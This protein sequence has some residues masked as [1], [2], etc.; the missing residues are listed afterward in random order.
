MRCSHSASNRRT[1]A[2]LAVSATARK[3]SRGV[4]FEARFSGLPPRNRRGI[5]ARNTHTGV[6]KSRQ[7]AERQAR[8]HHDHEAR[9]RCDPGIG[10][11]PAIEAVPV[12]PAY[13]PASPV[14]V[15]GTVVATLDVGI[16]R[17]S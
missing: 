3:Q 8:R 11:R 10:W 12:A 4:Q 2:K 7:C 13:F 5:A 1:V 17:S 9:S 15:R 16:A 14:I 6:G